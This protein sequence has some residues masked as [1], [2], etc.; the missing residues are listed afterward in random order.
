MHRD[1]IAALEE[2]AEAFERAATDDAHAERI[3]LL[4]RAASDARAALE[5]ARAQDRRDLARAQALRQAAEAL[6]ERE[7][8]RPE[9]AATGRTR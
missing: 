3:R 2:A 9:A 4:E 1:A 6:R 8:A 7:A 5:H